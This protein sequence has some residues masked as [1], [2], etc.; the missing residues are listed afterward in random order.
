MD[1]VL[2]KSRY[3]RDAV[4]LKEF[5]RHYFFTRPLM[6]CLHVLYALVFAECVVLCTLGSPVAIGGCIFL[7]FMMGMHVLSYHRTVKIVLAREAE[8]SGGTMEL[9][10]VMTDTCIRSTT[11]NGTTEVG[12]DKIKDV[13]QT[14]NLILIRTNAKLIYILPKDSFEI[15]NKETLFSLCEEKGI[16]VKGKKK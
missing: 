13:S 8:V 9:E 11:A 15:G 6:I 4:V 14:K 16:R 3:V 2:I 1:E 12:Y 5:Y 7:A 10:M